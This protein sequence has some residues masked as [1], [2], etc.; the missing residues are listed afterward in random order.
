MT[1]IDQAAGIRLPR[2]QSLV[3]FYSLSPVL[4]LNISGIFYVFLRTAQYLQRHFN[5]MNPL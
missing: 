5:L 4:R 1:T 3:F 2:L